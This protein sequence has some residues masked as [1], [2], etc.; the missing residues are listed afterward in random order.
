MP[1]PMTILQK[2][3]SSLQ[4]QLLQLPLTLRPSPMSRDIIIRQEMPPPEPEV[5]PLV[6]INTVVIHNTEAI[7]RGKIITI[8]AF[9]IIQGLPWSL[10]KVGK[11]CKSKLLTTATTSLTTVWKFHNF[12]IT[13]IFT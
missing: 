6:I 7:I 9:P 12:A 1:T 5:N 8:L 3:L 2:P 13:Q 4:M 11:T 10:F